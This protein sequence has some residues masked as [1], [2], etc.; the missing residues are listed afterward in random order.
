M[1]SGEGLPLGTQSSFGRT[2]EST[3]RTGAGRP[4]EFC[5]EDVAEIIHTLVLPVTMYKYKS[6]TVK[7]A[8]RKKKK[9]LI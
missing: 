5:G 2:K 1:L 4:V 6:W 9:E 8:D 7:M 3:G